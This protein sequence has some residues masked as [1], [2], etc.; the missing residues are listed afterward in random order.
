MQPGAHAT[1]VAAH[2]RVR[3]CD[4][5]SIVQ[6]ITSASALGLHPEGNRLAI[7]DC[8]L[9]NVEVGTWGTDG[10]V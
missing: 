4:S 10:L 9:L 8:R 7:D 1:L 3:I 5:F 6:A 2:G